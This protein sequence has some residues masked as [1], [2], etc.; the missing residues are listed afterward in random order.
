MLRLRTLIGVA[1]LVGQVSVSAP[2]LAQ[3]TPQQRAACTGDALRLCAAEVPNVSRITSCMKANFS[4][5]SAGCKAVF[6]SRGQ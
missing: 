3:G 6:G 4:R 1:I 2:A 5:L